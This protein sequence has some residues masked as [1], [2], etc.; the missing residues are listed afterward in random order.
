MQQQQLTTDQDV[1]EMND[2]DETIT[3]IKEEEPLHRKI[4]LHHAGNDAFM[5]GY[6][7]L[8]NLIA[9]HKQPVNIKEFRKFQEL[10]KFKN[11]IFLSSK[12]RPLNV[13]KSSYN[14]CSKGHLEKFA[15]INRKYNLN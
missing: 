6:Y 10:S 8:F 3:T 11:K 5:T 13:M 14:K 9:N 4:G 12:P 1:N 2:D 7:F 15:N